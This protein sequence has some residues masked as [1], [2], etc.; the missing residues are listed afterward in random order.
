M[1]YLF[2][3]WPEPAERDL[4][5]VK[6]RGLFEAA[7]YTTEGSEGVNVTVQVRTLSTL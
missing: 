2:A 5:W 7:T 6:K 1:L 3:D 4:L